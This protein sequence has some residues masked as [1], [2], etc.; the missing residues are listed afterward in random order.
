VI[1]TSYTSADW[2]LR[3]TD[4]VDF[5]AFEGVTY[6][7]GEGNL[8]ANCHQPRRGIAD[9][10]D[11]QIEVTSTHWGPH[12][13]GQGAMILGIAG[14]G[15]IEGSPGAHYSMVGDTCVA[16]HLGDGDNHTFEPDVSACTACHA[17]AESLDINGVQTEVS[18][19][20][21]IRLWICSLKL[22]Q[23]PCGTGSSSL[24]RMG[25]WVSTI[26]PTQRPCSKRVWKRWSKPG[27]I[28]LFV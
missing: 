3:T 7:G 19:K 4:P 10:V 9:A 8:C 15:G 1:H 24:M 27:T 2:A 14:A 13:G 22:M 12:H 18:T 26:H 11:G 6:D 16:C 23:P 20:R 21:G 17:D 5:Y 28:P 25:V